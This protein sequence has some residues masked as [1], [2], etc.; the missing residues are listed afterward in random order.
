[1]YSPCETRQ[2]RRGTSGGEGRGCCL[3]GVRGLKVLAI[4]TCVAL[5]LGWC[6]RPACL[7]GFALAFTGLASFWATILAP[8]LTLDR[9]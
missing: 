6:R 3:R 8:A 1:M 4:L 9:L 7:T 5:G 2:A